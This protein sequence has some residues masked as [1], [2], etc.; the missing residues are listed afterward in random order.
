MK[1]GAPFAAV[2]LVLAATGG[3]AA[4]FRCTDGAGRVT[5]QDVACAETTTARATDIPT[6]FPPPNEA[7]RNRL[8][9]REAQLEQRLEARRER[10]AR[11]AA[12]RA[13]S[14]PAPAP[15]PEPQYTEVYP[16]YLP[17]A[18]PRPHLRP[19]KQRGY[20][21]HARPLPYRP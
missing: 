9:Q 16:L 20:G 1:A 3:Q 4:V 6:E 2:G 5:Y 18:M 13:A 17:Y 15:A 11:D 21:S 10:E 7:E 8:L 19:P 14:T 12:L